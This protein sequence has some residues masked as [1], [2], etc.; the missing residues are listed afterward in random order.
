LEILWKCLQAGATLDGG[1]K[2][3]LSIPREVRK[4]FSVVDKESKEVLFSRLVKGVTVRKNRTE[5]LIEK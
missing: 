1:Y 2:A 4:M 5:I 3:K